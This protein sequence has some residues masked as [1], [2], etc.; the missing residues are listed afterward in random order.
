MTGEILFIK[1]NFKGIY[2]FIRCEDGNTYYYDTS[3]IVKGNYLKA[4][5]AVEFDI[6]FW[7]DEKTKAVNVRVIQSAELYPELENEK[8]LEVLE[9]LTSKLKQSFFV[10]CAIVPELLKSKGINYKEYASD[11]SSFIEK[12]FFGVFNVKKRIEINGKKYPAVIIQASNSV[13]EISEEKRSQIEN[14]LF[15]E[16]STNG[17]FEAS[18]FPMILQECEITEYRDYAINMDSFIDKFFPNKFI[19]KMNVQVNGKRYIKIYVQTEKADEFIE[20]S[21]LEKTTN[22][23]KKLVPLDAE[24]VSV[25][26]DKMNEIIENRTYFLAS[27]IPD[28]L[29]KF[30]IE[31][32]QL[33]AQTIENF[34][35]IY[36]SDTFEMKKNIVIDGKVYPNVIV[37]KYTICDQNF[38]L[39]VKNL[40][41]A[42]DYEG[43][44]KLEELHTITPPMLGTDG[45]QLLL[46]VLLAY[47]GE[48]EKKADLNEFQKILIRTEK[49]V[50]LKQF[51]DNTKLLALGMETS[52]ISTGLDEFKK[53]FA[54]VHNGKKNFNH[55]WNG[56]I[57]RFWSAK[58]ELAV[59]L[60]CLWVI[61][62]KKET[63]ID[64]YIEEAGKDNRIDKLP[65][66]LKVYRE[67]VMG[68]NKY[69]STSL[70]RKIL[71]HCFDCHDIHSL[72]DSAKFFDED[73]I[74]EI[75]EVIEF[76]EEKRIVDSEDFIRW[77]HSDIGA[78]VSEKITNYY[79][80]SSSA[81]GLNANM[82]KILASLCWEYPAGYFTE[83]IYNASCPMFGRKEKEQILCENFTQLCQNTKTYKK[84]YVLLNYLYLN[85]IEKLKDEELDSIWNDLRIWM[86]S[87]VLK[88]LSSDLRTAS[89]IEIFRYDNELRQEIEIYYCDNFIAEKVKN[90]SEDELDE[91]VEE[92]EKIGLH[93][94]TQWIVDNSGRAVAQDEEW[95]IRSLIS[96]Q[97]FHE[98]IQFLQQGT[99][100]EKMKK[101]D[102]LREILSENFNMYHMSEKAYTMFP[103]I[104][105][106][107]VAESALLHHLTFMERNVLVALIAIYVYKKE[108]LKVAFLY[109]PFKKMHFN[110]HRKFIDD[111]KSRLSENNINPSRNMESHYDVMK[112]ALKVCDFKEF[113]D[114][115]NWAKKIPVP[116]TSKVYV[117]K[118]K[119][120][121]N[122]LKN[123]LS[124]SDYDNCW[125]QLVITAL[126]T[127]ND[128]KQD[129]LRYCIIASFVGRYGIEQ[130][131]QVLYGLVKNKYS[132]K[133]FTDYYTSLWKGLSN[134]R[135]SLNFLIL[136]QALI[137]EA[138]ITFWN[139]FYDIA[140]CKN[141]VFSMD[142]FEF[143]TWKD[144]I[145]EDQ[146][147]YNGILDQYSSTRETV[148]L[149]IAARILLE[150]NEKLEPS[151]EK[152]LPYCNS[153]RK[154]DFLFSALI[155]L[156]Y[157]GKYLQEISELLDSNYWRCSEVEQ[158]LTRML[159]AFCTNKIDC[160]FEDI[161]RIFSIAE[162]ESFR[163]DYL[164]CVLNYPEINMVQ[165]I[166]ES[167][168][169]RTYKYKLMEQLLQIKNHD[170]QYYDSEYSAL[171][172]EIDAVPEIL[173]NWNQSAEIECYLQFVI[174]FYRQQLYQES[175][176]VVYIRNRYYRI[177]AASM[178]LE[179][180]F[181]QYSD[182]D[183]VALMKRNKHFTGVYSGYESFKKSL[184]EFMSLSTISQ[185][186]KVIFIIGLI[187][188]V[189]NQFI[190][191]RNEYDRE[192]LQ[193][194]KKIE[195][196]TNYRDLNI[197]LIR[198]FV[199]DRQG[200][201]TEKE[202]K[203]I[204]YCSPNIAFVVKQMMSIKENSI[205]GYTQCQKLING[206]CRLNNSGKA[207]KSYENL[208]HYLKVFS[209]DLKENWDMY[210]VALMATSY[211][212]TI[213]VNLAADIRHNKINAEEIKLWMPVLESIDELQTYY[214]L[215][216]V[217]YAIDR[218]KED[219]Q[220][221]Y[222]QITVSSALPDEWRIE[223]N[224]L[225]AYVSGKQDSFFTSS[226]SSILSLVTEKEAADISFLHNIASDTKMSMSE[227]TIAY[228][229]IIRGDT[230][231]IIKFD[232]Y[233]RLFMFVQKP[234][235]LY[236]I[237][238][239]IEG[240]GAEERR[241]RLTY[242]ELVIEYGSLLIVFSQ[243]FSIN[244][245]F[246][247]LSEIFEVYNL[248]NDINKGKGNIIYRLKNAEQAV[249]ETPGLGF[250]IWIN[251]QD[252]IK[253]I[254]LHPI[255][256]CLVSVF[257]EWVLSVEECTSLLSSCSTEMQRLE[258]LEKWRKNWNLP[259][260][261]SDYENAFIYSLDEEI[262]RLK[263]GA[264]LSISVINGKLEDQSIFYQIE[265][266]A[267]TSNLS[268]VL[269]NTSDEN[270]AHLE[271][272]IGVNGAELEAYEGAFFTN[273]LELRPGDICGQVYRLHNHVLSSL[274]YSDK[275]E[276]IINVVVGD[277]I[278]CNNSRQKKIFD[279]VEYTY[280]LQPGVI[281]DIKKYEIAVPAFSRTIEG[282]GR[283]IEKQRI[284]D[285]LEQQLV[286]IYGPSRVGKSSLLNYVSNQYVHE[287]SA[288]NPDIAIMCTMVADEQC[289]KNDYKLSM[290]DGKEL[291]F[292]NEFQIMD[293][294]FITPMR[295]AFA[296]KSNIQQRRRCKYVGEK[297]SESIK[298]EIRNILDEDGT[299]RDKYAY[300]SQ[301]LEENNCEV[302]IL[303][304]EFQQMIAYWKGSSN[305]LAELCNDIKYYQNSIKLIFCGS[306]A[307]LR[308]FQCENNSDWNEFKNITA[309]N[310][311]FV[312]SLN[313]IDFYD[314]MND[315]NI[316]SGLPGSMPWSK[317][318][319]ELLYKYTGGN[320]ICGK[321]FGNELL[322]KQRAGEF[323]RRNFIYPSDITKTAYELLHSE[324]GMVKNLLVLHNTKNLDDEMPYL[325]FIAYE[326]MNDRNKSD[327]SLRKIREFFA[328]KS[329]QD[330]DLAIKIL[331]ARGILKANSEKK[332]YGF[333]TMF[334][335]DFFRSQATDTQMQKI[336]VVEHP[337][338]FEEKSWINQ[339]KNSILQNDVEITTSSAIDI[340]DAM[341][342]EVQVGIREYYQR[343]AG[344]I[345]TLKNDI[346][347]C[348]LNN[349]YEYLET[350]RERR[351]HGKA[352]LSKFKLENIVIDNEY[353]IQFLLFAY[354]K[355]LFP[356]ER[357][358]V[359][360]DTG[361]GTVRTDILIDKD[362]CI[363]VKC[364]R[365]SMNEKALESQIKEDM[366]HYKQKNIFFFI[367]DKDKIVRNPPAF[368]ECY[369]EM[370]VGKNIYVVIHQPKKL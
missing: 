72:I 296:E 318:A 172:S 278:I 360:E 137:L 29:K 71:G 268:I 221:A 301:I 160:F 179:R 207:K 325:I 111:V 75:K 99:S 203:F 314:M 141:H 294:L 311:V 69:I 132:V 158:R 125:K 323:R 312:G 183:I 103:N 288:K 307:L 210:M 13:D 83:I 245:K 249:L 97:Q 266:I 248:L 348:V 198:L 76:L 257:N 82:F 277:R 131:N 152:Y 145:R 33:Y 128:D 116:N 367:Y 65:V 118:V 234:D 176:D 337:G 366:V 324:V 184:Y 177:L 211:K 345:D 142:G 309:N 255:I 305:E 332:R 247:V 175:D 336:S 199:F 146:K 197:Q 357:L 6:V 284:R 121:D 201:I 156:V 239:Q 9:L 350:L 209:N 282:F 39:K 173:A 361:Y 147:F 28:F 293:Y 269:S 77:F 164:K 48:N 231:D 233:K 86:K 343:E 295:I 139:M 237:Y 369:E 304:D 1:K 270:A 339:M 153:S 102:M 238:R 81:Q 140:I 91:F 208:K 333:T 229:D 68:G 241:R 120:F 96:S 114:F 300:I 321:L 88:Q 27:D 135:Y 334:Y 8:K 56:I 136:S 89:S 349:F 94:I 287:Y 273:E 100:F 115:V 254:I 283:D 7:D 236:E 253:E 3:S 126:R 354:L 134:G 5:N 341:P 168:Y 49:V 340:I 242:N 53:I 79:W 63:C 204:E 21:W 262:K 235:D 205:S 299:V 189:W 226:N 192:S 224:N 220:K 15:D 67:I 260:D 143:Q 101:V 178:L 329:H 59:Y 170:E 85:S 276:V 130:F 218:K 70:K 303:F 368:K 292:D 335:Y 246:E 109:A 84:A 272:F 227:A 52:Y 352:T 195:S 326:L 25:V 165:T 104:I 151:F 108:W 202:I 166:R 216:A 316:W 119:T 90:S 107:E 322:E 306:D 259:Q 43:I 50:N 42:C 215:L 129:N 244:Q 362:T 185:E 286:M 364:S 45:I 169:G 230:E 264:N 55:S 290:L 263:S 30:G 38:M 261:C 331:I 40:Y 356:K 148:F 122:T 144:V 281:S 58:N 347:S 297:F 31:N 223:R 64:L 359:S 252:R 327:V 351:L 271:V 308:L 113:D 110:A 355:P 250:E 370:M 34:I 74:P 80:W 112:V 298:A 182:D 194:I 315:R 123:M 73:S 342:I 161:E 14:K 291:T 22:D 60:T 61:I 363:E 217:R 188:N 54:D 228:K 196:Y 46:K 37:I 92:C 275:V 171:K 36:F 159:F 93:F 162:I 190:D 87:Q 240:K 232:A 167:I 95:Y 265:N 180:D 280:M 358:E 174:T 41:D 338:L 330:V 138:P 124:E 117:P 47:L 98:A 274:K 17:F 267:D 219:A 193:V 256:D 10:N 365:L 157:R 35:E 243:E 20:N 163:K 149:K 353:D 44:L 18:K 258:D 155:Q 302:W 150:S 4:G 51:K 78:L 11:L 346:L 32:Y 251:K 317:E 225:E 19:S 222:S 285:Y 200:D 106:V 26:K 214:Y 2:G 328:T 289:S 310:C 105:P 279:Y 23:E 320:A 344:T 154:K 186:L 206:I 313:D 12:N 319:L 181:V 213:V 133:S 57:E 16:I 62:C 191:R 127:D 187:S 212:K 24:V 66:I